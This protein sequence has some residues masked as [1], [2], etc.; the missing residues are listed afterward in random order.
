[1]IE[2]QPPQVIKTA[3]RFSA[4]VRLDHSS[5]FYTTCTPGDQCMVAI[6]ASCRKTLVSAGWGISLACTDIE[7]DILEEVEMLLSPCRSSISSYMCLIP[8]PPTSLIPIYTSP[9]RSNSHTS[10]CMSCSH[11]SLSMSDSHAALSMSDSHTS[12]STH[13]LFCDHC[14]L[15]VGGK[16]QIHLG[17][18][19]VT[20][21]IIK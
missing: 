7:S 6:S 3:N 15:L 19:E 13:V 16:L 21:T 14:R 12:L 4:T 9:S 2:K 10:P 8:M 18:P 1:M 17:V 5:L 11:T 20:V